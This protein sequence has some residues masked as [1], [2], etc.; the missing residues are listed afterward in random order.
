MTTILTV[1]SLFFF[2]SIVVYNL[3]ET[4]YSAQNKCIWVSFVSGI[5]SIPLFI[6]C[7]FY[8]VTSKLTICE[9]YRIE[10]TPYRVIITIEGIKKEYDD[11]YVVININ[12]GKLKHFIKEEGFNS[13]GNVVVTKYDFIFND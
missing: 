8:P 7:L 5:I 3:P 11:A 6:A 4:T 10:K 12:N 1:T 9:N 2:A 13:W